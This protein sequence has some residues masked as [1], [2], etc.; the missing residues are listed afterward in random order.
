MGISNSYFGGQVVKKEQSAALL[1]EQ[2]DNEE[3][4]QEIETEIEVNF[5]VPFCSVVFTAFC[6]W[7]LVSC[8]KSGSLSV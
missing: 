4:V 2:S 5:T 7:L 8:P 1:Q 6:S 3:A